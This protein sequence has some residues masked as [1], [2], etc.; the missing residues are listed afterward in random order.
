MSL[1]KLT[2]MFFSN[3]KMITLR[4][5]IEFLKTGVYDIKPLT[6]FNDEK[7]LGK[8]FIKNDWHFVKQWMEFRKFI[9]IKTQIFEQ[10][11]HNFKTMF[12]LYEN[13]ISNDQIYFNK[14]TA[15]AVVFFYDKNW[16]F[17]M[18]NKNFKLQMWCTTFQQKK[19][20]ILIN[21]MH[22]ICFFCV[23]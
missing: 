3:F 15:S 16:V 11:I 21:I 22:K 10:F 18:F 14:K 19:T 9:E 17:V 23:W 20:I 1:L 5:N 12:M 4:S 6:V 8:I 7:G 2:H 13:F